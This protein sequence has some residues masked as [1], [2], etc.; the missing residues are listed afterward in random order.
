MT[1]VWLTAIGERNNVYNDAKMEHT[2]YPDWSTCTVFDT[3]EH[4]LVY[5]TDY[6]L[7]TFAIKEDAN[8]CLVTACGCRGACMSRN[9]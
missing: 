6:K 9:D 7:V 5:L 2:P 4:K 1:G 3:P 8:S